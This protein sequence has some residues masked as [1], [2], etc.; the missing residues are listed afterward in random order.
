MTNLSQPK[1]IAPT[2]LHTAV[3]EPYWNEALTSVNDHEIR[4]SVMTQPFGWHLHPDSDETFLVLE[5]QVAITLEEAEVI[6]SPGEMFTVP[7]GTL[8]KTRPC[9]ERSVN[10]TFERTNAPTIFTA[11]KV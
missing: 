1:P 6:L 8:H 4:M 3:K 11:P 7:R 5:G 9:S 2:A 10:L